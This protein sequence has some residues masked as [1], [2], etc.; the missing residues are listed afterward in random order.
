MSI[1]KTAEQKAKKNARERARRA[2]KAGSSP[3]PTRAKKEPRATKG[4][5]DDPAPRA[6][7]KEVDVTKLKPGETVKMLAATHRL[8]KKVEKCEDAHERAKRDAREAK[9]KLEKARTALRKEID[10]QRFG[11]GELFGP[12]AATDHVKGD[13]S[14]EEDDDDGEGELAESA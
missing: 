1:A 8:Q 2:A 9:A 12:G 11:P 13:T 10:E 4:E 6:R 7:G 14:G 3:K 5:G